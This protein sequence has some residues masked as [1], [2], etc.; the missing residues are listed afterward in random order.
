MAEVLA[1]LEGIGCWSPAWADWSSAAS[2]LRGGPVLA[3]PASR[4]PAA[5]LAAGERRRAAPLV[6]LACEVGA[7]ACAAAGR[8]PAALPVVF[9]SG[10]GDVA[11]ADA[12]CATLAA[13]PFSLSPTRFHNSVHNAAVGYWTVAA[14]CHAASTAIAAGPGSLAAGL[15]EAAAQVLADNAP[16]LFLACE[17]AAGGPLAAVLG[18]DET[19][20]VALVLA[21]TRSAR[22]LATLRLRHAADGE[23]EGGAQALLEALARNA[24]ATLRLAA[25][26]GSALEVT[27]AP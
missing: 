24:P 17:A 2:A 5:M 22:T 10:H 16:V 13:D 18:A 26:P 8:D 14:A 7:Q 11:T 20:G 1:Y 6:L 27:L 9:A 21:P 19:L 12:I 4:P 15:L 3:A 23:G 25:G